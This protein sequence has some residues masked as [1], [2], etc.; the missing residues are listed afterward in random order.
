[1]PLLDEKN[2][3]VLRGHRLMLDAHAAEVFGVSTSELRRAVSKNLGR[4]P[5]G[6]MVRLNKAECKR[7]SLEGGPMRRFIDPKKNALAFSR[8][9]F[10]MLSS[11]LKSERAA[12]LGVH[13]IRA[14]YSAVA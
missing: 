2:I 12:A 8:Y 10:F 11:I 3:L 1:M 13:I 6:F 9:G 14:L 7:I 4:F 5:A